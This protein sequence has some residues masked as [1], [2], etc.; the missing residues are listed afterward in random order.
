MRAYRG[1]RVSRASWAMTAWAL[2]TVAAA[3]ADYDL[4]W[5]TIDSGGGMG[6]TGGAFALSGTIGQLD[7]GAMMTGGDFAL[8]G[9]FW[10]VTL[11]QGPAAC[12]GDLN[13]DGQVDFGD[14]NP[15]VLR[16][17]NPS[18]YA[19][20]YPDCPDANGDINDDGT[21]GFAD[22][23]PFVQLMSTGQGPCP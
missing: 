23:N 14:I 1:I 10:A 6:S 4:S 5:Y 11:P 20:Q 13:C 16:L 15:F 8:T 12:A 18:A 22:I 21:V 2:F 17:S 7:A 19:L 3:T 9:G